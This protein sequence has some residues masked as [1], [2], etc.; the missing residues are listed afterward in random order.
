MSQQTAEALVFILAF[1]VVVAFG[2][3]WC[4]GNWWE[5]RKKN[6]ATKKG[7]Q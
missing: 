2:I 1:L 4:I 6:A 3:A 7:R 5:E